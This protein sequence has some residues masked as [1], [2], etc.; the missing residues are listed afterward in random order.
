MP[1]CHTLRRLRRGDAA[2]L[3]ELDRIPTAPLAYPNAPAV[4][5]SVNPGQDQKP[6]ARN[7]TD[8][9]D[10]R[11]RHDPTLLIHDAYRSLRMAT[12]CP[13]PSSR[14]GDNTPVP[15]TCYLIRLYDPSECCTKYSV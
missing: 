6:Y 4:M 15:V 7:T 9:R 13:A 1:I 12:S 10:G 14:E 11:K 5:R 8:R 2:I 3:V